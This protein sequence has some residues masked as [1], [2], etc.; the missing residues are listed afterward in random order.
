M[1]SFELLLRGSQ[2]QCYPLHMSDKILSTTASCLVNSA[3]LTELI[4]KLGE[5]GVLSEQDTHDI[6]DRALESLER[7]QA[8]V[9]DPQL[10]PVYMQ[11]RRMIEEPLN[12]TPRRS[13]N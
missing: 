3:L 12:S 10:R 1:D 6:Y 4:P 2:P 5:L 8:E 11:A 13:R 7:M 9:E